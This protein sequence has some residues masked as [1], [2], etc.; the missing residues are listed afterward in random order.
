MRLYREAEARAHSVECDRDVV[1][2]PTVAEVY[3]M[4]WGFILRV[5]PLNHKPH[6]DLRPN[7]AQHM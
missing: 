7:S 6:N 5:R 2:Q 1:L 3:Y 4:H